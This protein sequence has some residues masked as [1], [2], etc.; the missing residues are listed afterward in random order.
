MSKIVDGKKF[1]CIQCGKCCRW[2]GYVLLNDEDISRLS[3]KL[4]KGNKLDF[5]ERY[6]KRIN[7]QGALALADKIDKDEC[8]FLSSDKCSIYEDRPT[9]CKEFPLH[10][11]QRCPGF[12]E[13]KE[14]SVMSADMV[15]RIMD[16]NKKLSSEMDF[17]KAVTDKLY[18]GL[19]KE[20]ST[21]SVAAKAIE[22]GVGAFF[23]DD[24]RV[25]IASLD[26]LFAFNRVDDKHLIHK[27]T[28]DL[29]AIEADDSGDVHITRLF[30]S[31]KPVKG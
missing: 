8:I 18:E 23:D 22:S 26:D 1:E 15:Q 2:P 30:D 10:Y 5:I 19:R 24:E 21:A 20:A 16:M 12:T 13:M 28:R 17:E 29:W 25:K 6:T 14:V 9:Q 4:S 11:D 31:G 27:A 3:R 7:P